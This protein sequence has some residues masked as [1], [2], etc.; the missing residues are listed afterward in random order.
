MRWNELKEM[1][2]KLGTSRI[3]GQINHAFSIIFID[4]PLTCDAS[5]LVCIT[6]FPAISIWKAARQNDIESV[7]DVFW[8]GVLKI[9]VFLSYVR[10]TCFL[11]TYV[12][13][14]RIAEWEG[15]NGLFSD[16]EFSQ[17]NNL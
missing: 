14:S 17:I 9:L 5:Y 16:E 13:K 7:F 3:A 8:A 10:A 15:Q 1:N 4:I 2:A 12:V 11:V 6:S